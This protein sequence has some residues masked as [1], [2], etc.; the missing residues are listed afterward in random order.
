MRTGGVNPGGVTPPPP[1]CFTDFNYLFETDGEG[2][3]LTIT[4][5]P[6]IDPCDDVTSVTWDFGDGSNVYVGACNETVIH[7]FPTTSSYNVVMTVE[8]TNDCDAYWSKTVNTECT[9]QGSVTVL[10]ETDIR[11][12]PDLAAP[13]GTQTQ[14]ISINTCNIPDVLDGEYLVG[15]INVNV[16][17]CATMPIYIEP[18]LSGQYAPFGTTCIRTDDEEFTYTAKH[19]IQDTGTDRVFTITS[20]IFDVNY[21]GP[22]TNVPILLQWVSGPKNSACTIDLLFRIQACGETD[23]FTFG[24]F[25]ISSSN[26][27]C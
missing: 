17:C 4:F 27:P 3:S 20:P 6:L 1:G 14:Y 7:T 2:E 21:N 26:N 13:N 25:V 8:T 11:I 16:D 10:N 9:L 15:W 22:Y 12:L 24:Y 23:N 18:R 5:V 19:C